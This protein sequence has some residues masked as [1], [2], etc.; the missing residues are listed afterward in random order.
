M[1]EQP[2][3]A[4]CKLPVLLGGVVLLAGCASQPPP[5]YQPRASYYQ[6]PQA[7]YAAP[8]YPAR[9]APRTYAPLRDDTPAHDSP[10]KTETETVR[11][12]TPRISAPPS[13]GDCVG[14]WRICHFL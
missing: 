4:R 13:A 3:I 5:A 10:P 6:P 14:W 8:S 9:P 7:Y 12:E 1:E 11:R 2:M